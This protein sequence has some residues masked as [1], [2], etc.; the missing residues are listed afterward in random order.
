MIE[1]SLLLPTRGRPDGVRRLFDSIVETA[2][3]ASRLEVV[4]YLDE[5]DEASRGIQSDMLRMVTL[6]GPPRQPMGTMTTACYEASRGRYLMLINDDV[7]CRTSDWDLRVTEAFQRYPDGIALVHGNDL[8]QGEHVPSFPFIPR[9]ACEVMGELCPREYLNLHIES[10]LADIFRRLAKLGHRRTIYLEHVIFEHLYPVLGKARADATSIKR[11]PARDHQ[12]YFALQESRHSMA[13]K[14]ARHIELR[15]AGGRESKPVP[16]VENLRPP[17]AR[18]AI[19]LIV[20][21]DDCEPP[22]R[23]PG[24]LRELLGAT[25]GRPLETIA[26]GRPA[27]T[28]VRTALE[29]LG[30]ALPGEV[31]AE[32]GVSGRALNAAVARATGEYIAYVP[33]GARPQGDWLGTALAAAEEES[34]AV[35]GAKIVHPRNGRVLHA[36]IAFF[37]EDGRLL[38]THL[39]RGFTSEHPAV[40]RRRALQALTAVGMVIRRSALESV[41]GFAPD[42]GS[43]LLAAIELC[44]RLRAKDLRVVYVPAVTVC[45]NDSPQLAAALAHGAPTV[46]AHWRHHARP[47][48][49]NLL[50]EDGFALQRDPDGVYTLGPPHP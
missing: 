15:Q 42:L 18:P 45:H 6:V 10:H 41:G 36:G 48:L 14:L 13:A 44:L 50:A 46:A 47:D 29:K 43:D 19:S 20:G 2:G 33:A 25:G 27:T 38:F 37:E 23:Y 30:V 3:D 7:V 49:D 16:P 39:Y 28:V 34:A 5:D 31:V 21:L 17:A 12:L 24:W 8:D 32:E 40:N 11:D 26:V 9:R 22:A 35:V 1:F 4:L